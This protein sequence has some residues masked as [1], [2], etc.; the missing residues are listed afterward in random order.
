MSPII[1]NSNLLMKRARGLSLKKN[2][3]REGAFLVEG[4]QPT[5][6]AVESGWMV[7]VLIVSDELLHEPHARDMV[8][9]QERCGVTV[10]RVSASL[11]A[12]ISDR[13]GPTGIA[14]IVRYRE[15]ALE[16]LTVDNDTVVVA[17]HQVANP[18]NLGT[19]IRTADACN[20]AGVILLGNSTDPWSPQAVKASMGSI[21]AVPIIR[22]EPELFLS[23]TGHNG[24]ETVATSGYANTAHWDKEYSLPCAIMMGSEGTGLPD[25]LIASADKCVKIPMLGTTE[26]LNLAVS[27]AIMLYEVNR[28]RF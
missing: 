8:N 4:L 22:C 2:R 6:R 28:H 10:S 13:D 1:S 5:W 17:L 25:T 21:F 9:D 11:F 18:G 7:E 15:V 20:V 23:W 3:Q 14:A 26:S 12:R 24:V 16:A 19:I 27:T